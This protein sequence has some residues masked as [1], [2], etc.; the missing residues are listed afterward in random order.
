MDEQGLVSAQTPFYCGE[1]CGMYKPGFEDASGRKVELNSFRAP[2]GIRDFVA[3]YTATEQAPMS[4]FNPVEQPEYSIYNQRPISTRTF[5]LFHPHYDKG[6]NY[7]NTLLSRH[8]K[9]PTDWAPE[10]ETIPMINIKPSVNSKMNPRQYGGCGI[11]RECTDCNS[12]FLVDNRMYPSTSFYR[13]CK[14]HDKFYFPYNH[15]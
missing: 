6:G 8:P 13:E 11:N 15:Y 4:M 12:A 5:P 2:A 9:Y 14:K 3:D 10:L 1:Y 7:K